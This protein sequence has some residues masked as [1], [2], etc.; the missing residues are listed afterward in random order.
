MTWLLIHGNSMINYIICTSCERHH[1]ILDVRVIKTEEDYFGIGLLTYK[2]PVT[3]KISKAYI[4]DA[5][6]NDGFESTLHDAPTR[7][8]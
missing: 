4:M 3:N 7:I 2:C 8:F 1:Y 6:I 5:Y